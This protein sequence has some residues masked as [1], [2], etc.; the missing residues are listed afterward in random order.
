MMISAYFT[1]QGF[2]SVEALPETEQFNSTFFT[3]TVLPSIV[4]SVSVFCPTMEAQGY[5]MQMNKAKLP[6][7]A[8][9]FEKTE[10]F[11]CT[12]LTQPP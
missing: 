1:R 10:V 11:G 7:S 2:V 5:W 4:R 3:E 8:L 6:N 12:R 9:S